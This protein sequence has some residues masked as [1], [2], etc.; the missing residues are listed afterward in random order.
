MFKYFQQ[1]AETISPKI[2]WGHWFALFNIGLGLII[3]SRYAF[4]ADWPNTLF[5]KL[6]FFI[7]LFGHFSFIIFAVYVLLLF[8]LSF[9]I[10]NQRAFRAVSVVVATIGMSILLID[11]EVFKTLYLHLSPLVWKLFISPKGFDFFSHWQFI[12]PIF[13]ILL[14]EIASAYWVWH[15]LRRFGRQKWG[16]FVAVFFITCFMATH[17]FYAWADIMLYRPI[18]AQ[19]ANYPLSYPMTAKTFF[20]KHGLANRSILEQQVKQRGHSDAFYLD[21]PKHALEMKEPQQKVNFV[22][23]NISNLTNQVISAEK[24]PNLFEISQKSLNFTQHYTAGDTKIASTVNL[25]YG[26]TGQYVDS[27]LNEHKASPLITTL[28]HHQYKLGAFSANGFKEPIYHQALFNDKNVFNKQNLY[29]TDSNYQ[30]IQKWQQWFVNNHS[31]PFFSYLDLNLA[32]STQSLDKQI[33]QIWQTLEQ[34]E[35]LQNTLVIITSDINKT[36]RTNNSFEKLR[37]HIPMMIYWQEKSQYYQQL[38]SNLDIMP[39]LLN[40]FLGV[41]N[42]IS[43]YAQGINLMKDNDR[44]WLLSANHHWRVAIMPTNE[45]FQLRPSKGSFRYFDAQGK[46]QNVEPPLNLFLQLI[47][48]SNQFIEKQH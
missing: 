35:L 48:D 17:L 22:I 15:K 36:N 42:P 34:Q 30:A 33:A 1:R 11:T 38:S 40:E 18:T 37:T 3:A 8:P 5:G 31:T 12:I 28:Q 13:A 2:T 10:K 6:Y 39:T 9:I 20:E 47:L 16:K 29:P 32:Q 7:S 19:K 23:I 41:K 43:D 24:M 4:N 27:I 46:K 25:F 44:K 45:Q 21:Y 14:F 26:L